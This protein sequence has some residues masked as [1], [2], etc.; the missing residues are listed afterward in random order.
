[1]NAPIKLSSPATHEFWEIAVLWEDEHLLVLAKPSGLLTS[2]DRLD[3]Q[4]PSLMKLLHAGIKQGK[5][6]AESRALGYLANAHRLD[7]ETSGVL[8]LAKSKPILV[9]LADLFGAEKPLR[10]LVALVQGRPSSDRFEVDVRLAPHPAWPGLVRVDSRHGKRALTQFE[11]VE[12]FRDCTLLRCR[13]VTE[14]PHQI[15]VHLRQAGHPVMGD[16]LYGGA[17]LLLSQLKPGYRLKP[18]RIERPLISQAAIHAERVELVHPVTGAPLTF[19]APWPKDLSVAVKYLRR[20][21]AAGPGLEVP[22]SPA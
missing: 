20:Y 12:R 15:R 6:W 17:P 10:T 13:P 4:R 8:L 3:P 5:S 21:A 1:M 18:R 14:R 9:A 11:V 16:R 7:F 22:P 2:P 19:A